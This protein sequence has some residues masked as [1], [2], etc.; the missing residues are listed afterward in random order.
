MTAVICMAMMQPAFSNDRIK[1]DNTGGKIVNSVLVDI[2]GALANRATFRKNSVALNE[3]FS[4]F[5][6]TKEIIKD[7]IMNVFYFDCDVAT[8]GMQ[9]VRFDSREQKGKKIT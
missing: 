2:V 3:I 9:S 4:K 1:P 8:T 6:K 5:C 7:E